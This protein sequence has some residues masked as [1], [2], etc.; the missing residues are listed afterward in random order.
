VALCADRVDVRRSTQFGYLNPDRRVTPVGFFAD[1]TPVD[2]TRRNAERMPTANV[3]ATDAVSMGEA[4]H[5]PLSGRYNRTAVQNRDHITPGGDPT[6]LGG[7]HRFSRFTPPIGVTWSLTRAERYG[8]SDA[9]SRTPPPWNSAA[10]TRSTRA[11]CRTR[12][13]KIHRCAKSSP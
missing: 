9:G 2:S 7:D 10:P 3:F 6:L 11:S 4:L 12:W 13:Q 5:L 1:A 8:G